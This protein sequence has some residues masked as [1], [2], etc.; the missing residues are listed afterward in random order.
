MISPI[1]KWDGAEAYFTFANS[2]TLLYGVLIA[3][4]VFVVFA[5]LYD[6]THEAGAYKKVANGTTK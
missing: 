1:E 5:I 3:S 2:P 4:A 6:A